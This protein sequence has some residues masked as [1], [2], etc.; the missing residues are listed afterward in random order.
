MQGLRNHL[1]K[2]VRALANDSAASAWLAFGLA[3]VVR[4][5]FALTHP[6]LDNVF[7]VRGV[8]YSDAQQWTSGALW[9]TQGQ[10]F[11]SIL[12]PGLSCVL[13]LFYVWWGYSV[14]VIT[15]LNIFVGAWTAVFLFLVGQRI[16]PRPITLTATLFY[17]FDPSQII[18]IPQ[19][20]TEPLGL[21]FFAASVY[22]LL[23]VED[24]G[25]PGYALCAGCLLGLSNLTRPLTLFCAPFYAAVIFLSGWW[26]YRDYRR[27]V[28]MAIFFCGALAL[29]LAPWLIRQKSVH[30]VWAVST[31]LGEAFYGATSPKYKTWTS[32]VRGDAD[33]A[34]I[35]AEAGARYD[36][37]ISHGLEN[38]RRN[39]EF[40]SRQVSQAFSNYLTSFDLQTRAKRREFSYRQWTRLAEAQVL[41]RWVVACSLLIEALVVWKL[42]GRRPALVFLGAC[43][44]LLCVWHLL[45]SFAGILILALGVCSIR[46]GLRTKLA[47]L[48][49][50][51]LVTGIGGALF[52]NAIFYRAVLMTDWIFALLYIAAFH[53]SARF[54]TEVLTRTC[55]SGLDRGVKTRGRASRQALPA[56]HRWRRGLTKIGVC[57]AVLFISAGTIR[58]FALNLVFSPPRSSPEPYLSAETKGKVITFVG[59]KLQMSYPRSVPLLRQAVDSGT[60]SVSRERLSYYLFQFPRGAEFARRN[61]VFHRRAFACTIFFSS[62]GAAISAAKVPDALRGREV[63]LVQ[64]IESLGANKK[65]RDM[66]TQ[67]VAIIP[68]EGTELKYAEALVA[69]PRPTDGIL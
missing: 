32:L 44:L 57:G 20:T 9:L 64:W 17:I 16:F 53:F 27:S 29:T 11:Q 62:L 65:R 34:G 30:G 26:R 54:L 10:G 56:Q 8:P 12:R 14:I 59:Q 61:P 22:Y 41:F 66:V 60:L 23:L 21:L 42:Y 43:G 35:A 33:R 19:A 51:L 48:V 55:L 3:F 63:V 47:V 67:C 15:G 6:H 40:Y 69:S 2:A 58:L 46:K 36:Y 5:C 25:K 38:I 24:I 28:L 45:P 49:V 37:F 52:N 7:A 18:Q 4:L 50:S 31:N 13:A 39:P 68:V 1:Q